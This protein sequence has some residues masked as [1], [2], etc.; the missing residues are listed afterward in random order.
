MLILVS[1]RAPTPDLFGTPAT[2][3]KIGK[4]RMGGRYPYRA[5]T[6][7]C[8]IW[9][10]SPIRPDERLHTLGVSDEPGVLM[11]DTIVITDDFAG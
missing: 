2:Y 6:H 9:A 1:S 4:T 11:S 5:A 8:P 7:S 3:A 10:T